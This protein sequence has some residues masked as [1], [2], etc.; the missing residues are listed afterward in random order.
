M[1]IQKNRRRWPLQKPFLTP[2][3]ARVLHIGLVLIYLSLLRLLLEVQTAA[4]FHT[5]SAAYFGGMLEHIMAALTLLTGAVLL[6]DRAA[7]ADREGS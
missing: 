6:F 7:R 3:A 4:P 2:L 5:G 1:N